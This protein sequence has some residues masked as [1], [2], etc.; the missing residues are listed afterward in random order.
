MYVYL[1][2]YDVKNLEKNILIQSEVEMYFLLTYIHSAILPRK[3]F[4]IRLL[5]WQNMT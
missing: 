2:T 1:K 4:K 5:F 3:G